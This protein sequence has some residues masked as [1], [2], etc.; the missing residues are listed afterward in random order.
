[1]T[2]SICFD[3]KVGKHCTILFG[4][5]FVSS[6]GLLGFVVMLL[7]LHPF[8]QIIYSKLKNLNGGITIMKLP[9]FF[10]EVFTCV[11]SLIYS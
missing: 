11:A 3:W 10:W 7:L 2:V 6:L 5:N 1:M 4:S 8:I 9:H